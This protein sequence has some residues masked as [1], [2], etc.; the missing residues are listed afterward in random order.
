V[1]LSCLAYTL[2]DDADGT[3]VLA[4][5]V[6]SY[7]VMFIKVNQWQ[8][9][10]ESDI[11]LNDIHDQPEDRYSAPDFVT[12]F[13]RMLDRKPGLRP[14]VV[15]SLNLVATYFETREDS[16]VE[17][18]SHEETQ[19]PLRYAEEFEAL[20]I[21]DVV[22]YEW[23]TLWRADTRILKESLAYGIFF[24][25]LLCLPRDRMNIVHKYVLVSVYIL[26]L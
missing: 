15:R 23:Q 18:E 2:P 25:W 9:F 13:E 24:S 7:G 21:A 6:K 16:T 8:S 20:H 11:A 4:E 1:S 5:L 22:S 12:K 10:Q 26:G 17:D 19:Q 3:R 14:D